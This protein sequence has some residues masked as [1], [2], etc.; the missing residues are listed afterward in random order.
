MTEM[1][2]TKKIIMTMSNNDDDGDAAMSTG[3]NVRWNFRNLGGI[4]I[5]LF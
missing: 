5:Q 2:K 4:R 3:E 1:I